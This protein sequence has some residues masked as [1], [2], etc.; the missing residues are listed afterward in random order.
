MNAP[1]EILGSKTDNLTAR[2]STLHLHL[3]HSIPT[4]DRIGCA[5]YDKAEDV[6]KTFI[7]STRSGE[8]LKGYEIRMSECLSLAT[9]A[10]NGS[11][12]LLPDLPAV[13][14]P[15]TPHSAWLLRE[16]Y[17]SSFT[18]PM[19]D[20]DDFTGFTFFDSRQKNAF[21]PADQNVLLVYTNLISLMLA[22]ELLTIQALSGSVEVARAFCD[23][24]DFETGAHLERMARYARLIA[25]DIATDQGLPDEF[26]EHVFLF[27]PLHDI[28][29]IG[30]PDSILLKPGKLD[31][32]EWEIMKSHVSRGRAIIEKMTRGLNLEN[33]PNVT[34]MRNIV[35]YHHKCLDGS[36][37]PETPDGTRPPIE[38]RITAVADI[39]DALTTRRPYK[40]P[41]PVAKAFEELDR[42]VAAGKL[43]SACV[44]S[45]RQH[46]GTAEHIRD[47]F[48]DP[49]NT[50]G[51]IPAAG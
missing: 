32:K 8:A 43:D 38:A 3:L 22:H 37:Y 12:R 17:L 47:T 49:D 39:F 40:E 16:G 30:I 44:D 51:S 4:V 23:M 50:K 35:E 27:A 36:G 25:K 29:K 2:L 10:R 14:K 6:L 31:E 18:V 19:Y 13:L 28:G 48:M 21:A 34:I 1:S 45:L 20:Q 46:A 33:L 7:N 11:L 41:W 9:L 5:I 26:V 42:L 15:V 24:R